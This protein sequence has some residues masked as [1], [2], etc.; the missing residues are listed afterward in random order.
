[1]P[2]F[3]P[4]FS[5]GLYATRPCKRNIYNLLWSRRCVCAALIGARPTWQDL[6]CAMGGERK[7]DMDQMRVFL[8]SLP[9]LFLL[10][11][12]PPPH[13]NTMKHTRTIH[14]IQLNTGQPWGTRTSYTVPDTCTVMIHHGMRCGTLLPLLCYYLPIALTLTLTPPSPPDQHIDPWR[15]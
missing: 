6:F 8:C 3:T 1:V 10:F 13:H 14:L 2:R 11:F 15:P 7:K 9:L 4:R 5:G 12:H